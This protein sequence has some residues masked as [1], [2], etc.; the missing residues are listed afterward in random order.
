[1]NRT[2]S[3]SCRLLHLRV[4]TL[5]PAGLHHVSSVRH[6][7]NF[8]RFPHRAAVATFQLAAAGG[9]RKDRQKLGPSVAAA[10]SAVAGVMNLLHVLELLLGAI[11]LSSVPFVI[12]LTLCP[13]DAREESPASGWLAKKQLQG[14][15]QT[16]LATVS[17]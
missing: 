9:A 3:P 1:M 8:V 2:R 10:L 17:G 12:H 7:G 5:G 14:C 4:S 16:N 13:S 15:I 11:W 6:S